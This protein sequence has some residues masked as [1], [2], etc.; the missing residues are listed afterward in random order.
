MS[1]T[2]ST[3]RVGGVSK[4]AVEGGKIDQYGG[5]VRAFVSM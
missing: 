5:Q 3:D 4:F 1:F 2:R